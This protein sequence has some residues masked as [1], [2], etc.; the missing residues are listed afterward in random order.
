MYTRARARARTHTHTHTHTHLGTTHSLHFPRC[1]VPADERYHRQ[2]QNG[3]GVA[4]VEEGERNAQK[5][6]PETKIYHKK[7]THE[8]VH[9]LRRLLA[10][11]DT[12]H[13]VDLAR[14]QLASYIQSRGHFAVF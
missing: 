14:V 10:S 3:S 13:D 4:G 9:R 5:S 7:E 6:S 1:I 11:G 2:R 8:D 12:T